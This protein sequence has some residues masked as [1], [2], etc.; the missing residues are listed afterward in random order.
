MKKEIK[1]EILIH[2]SCQKVWSVLTNINDYPNWNPF[3]TSFVGELKIGNKIKARLQPPGAQGMTFTPTIL[4]LE[5]NKEFKWL[6]HLWVPGLFDGEHSFTLQEMGNGTTLFI[7]SEKFNGILVPLF[8]KMI[9]G[10]TIQGFHLMNQKL[11]EI[12]EKI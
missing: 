8:K 3:I 10:N 11:K 5:P 7:Q 12:C 2:A 9:E 6:G 4:T 1:T